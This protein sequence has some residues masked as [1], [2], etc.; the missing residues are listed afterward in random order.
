MGAISASALNFT[1]VQS[2]T[3]PAAQT[4]TIDRNGEKTKISIDPS[5]ARKLTSAEYKDYDLFFPRFPQEVS[6]VSKGSIAEKAGI[7][8][9]AK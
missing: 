5:F 9:L 1:M 4:L 7:K 3:N 8:H 6:E 2:G